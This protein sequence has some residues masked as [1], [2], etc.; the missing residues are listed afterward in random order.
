[1]IYFFRGD[2]LEEKN[3][4]CN[5][6]LVDCLTPSCEAGWTHLSVDAGGVDGG[7]VAYLMPERTPW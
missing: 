2:Y 3:Y 4:S 6:A 7:H 1:M 5:R